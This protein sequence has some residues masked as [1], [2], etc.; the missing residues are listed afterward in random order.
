[1]RKKR[2]LY[3]SA[4]IPQ[5]TGG[6]TPMRAASHLKVLAASFDVTLAI[7]GHAFGSEI[8][9][10][11]NLDSDVREACVSVVII[12]D[13]ARINRLLWRVRSPWARVLFEGLWPIPAEIAS[14]RLAV[15]ELGKRLAG[16]RFDVVQCFRLH[17][18]HLRLLTR[19]GLKYRRAVLDLD[20][21]ESQ[22]GF[23]SSRQLTSLGKQFST[24]AWLTALKWWL[25][26]FFLIRSFTDAVVCSELD[27]QRLLR[28][29]PGTDWH[30]VPNTVP[31]PPRFNRIEADPFTFLFVGRFDHFPNADAVYFFCTSVLPLL[32]K[33]AQGKFRVLI[34]GRAGQDLKALMTNG[35]VRIV[36]DPPD[37]LPFYAQSDAVI[38][39]LRGG[40]GTRIKI[41]EAFSYGLPVISTT[42]GAEGL[43]VTPERDIII[44][45]SAQGFAE[46]CLRIWRDHDLRQRIAQMGRDLWRRKY[47][48]EALIAA[49]SSVYPVAE[50][51][52]DRAAISLAQEIYHAEPR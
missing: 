40:G 25:L 37:V 22:A 26:E 52:R 39:P 4:R 5:S 28:R 6:G 14:C 38:V 41:I 49:F 8:E 13:I 23:R 51:G 44:A 35:E 42:I 12:R 32:Q 10:K 1:L 19:H 36:L 43:E 3:V 33:N 21:Y 48:P 34:V 18:G 45:D 50:P 27:R 31:E 30:A 15:A 7:V 20:D 17:T 24:L 11:K 9:L 29:F 46:Q 47:G 2:L 16:E